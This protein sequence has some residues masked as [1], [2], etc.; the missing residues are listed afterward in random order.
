MAGNVVRTC[1]SPGHFARFANQ[2]K[3]ILHDDTLNCNSLSGSFDKLFFEV[4]DEA[5]QEAPLSAQ[6]KISEILYALG[7]KNWL[8][9]DGEYSRKMLLTCC[10]QDTAASLVLLVWIQQP[11]MPR[12]QAI[13]V[14]LL[15][16]MIVLLFLC[17]QVANCRIGAL[18][19]LWSKKWK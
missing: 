17:L 10:D 13:W 5:P 16:I 8:N 7:G 11:A 2:I 6:G 3:T 12:I 9:L 14:F 18:F 1:W 4:E 15:L 19:G